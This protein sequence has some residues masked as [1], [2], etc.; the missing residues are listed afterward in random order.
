MIDPIQVLW[1]PAGMSMPSLGSQALVDVHDGDTPNIRMPVRMLSIDTPEVT[2]GSAAA[3][4]RIDQRFAD[5]AQW[6]NDGK[7]PISPG[8]AEYVLP[9]LGTGKAGTLQFEQGTAAAA[10][11]T[12]NVEQRLRRPD[13]SRRRVFVRTADS[14]F[15]THGRLLAYLAPDY[16]P[17][18]RVTMTRAERSTF[19]LDMITSGWGA[20]F[21]I[22]PSIPGELDLPLL[23]DAAATA[24]AAQA[25]AWADDLG[26][27]GYEYRSLERLHDITAKIVAGTDVPA[28][29]RWSWRERYCADM[30]DRVLHGPEDYPAVPPE[31]RLWFWAADVAEA[32]SRLNLT[33]APALVRP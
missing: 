9:K 27:P 10:F 13:G 14:P 29:D 24:R 28:A 7:A 19:N 15:D 26:M 22:Y 30:R 17:K 18:E 11:A 31:Y 12:S 33:P 2:A 16:S 1:S 8:F 23:I 4:A 21:V 5:L 20:T 3:A 25:G 32:V 6:I